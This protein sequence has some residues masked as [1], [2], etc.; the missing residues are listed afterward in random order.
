MN[1]LN[2]K[3]QTLALFIA[4]IPFF[5]MIG[6]FV[7]D[8]G[9]AKYNGNRLNE[10]T[11]MVVRYGLEHIDR[12]PYEEMVDLIYKND[13]DIDNYKID[14]DVENKIV[15]VSLD[16]ATKGFFGS[17]VGKKIYKEKSSYKGFFKDERIIIEEVQNEE[18]SS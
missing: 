9:Y 13:E 14:I 2:N 18:T 6:T 12:D 11:K 7:I 16:K 17:I 8:V 10:V 1:R 5:I 15:S 4:F 3:G